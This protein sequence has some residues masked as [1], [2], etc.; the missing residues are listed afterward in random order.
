MDKYDLTDNVYGR[1]TVLGL[2]GKTGHERWL[3]KCSCGEITY[4]STSNLT[5]GR[6]QSC[7]CLKRDSNKSRGTYV[8]NGNVTY[9]AW[10]NL[11]YNRTFYAAE[12]NGIDKVDPR[13]SEFENFVA[14]LGKKPGKGWYL[15]R[16]D[17][18]LPYNKENCEWAKMPEGKRKMFYYN[19]KH[20]H[21]ETN[22]TIPELSRRLSISE[23]TIYE[24]LRK[25]KT[26]LEA[27]RK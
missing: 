25:G 9:A 27:I 17:K 3:C 12:G 8:K 13:W 4:S 1:L 22:E 21:P 19:T 16:I 26:L 11:I 15:N 24:R 14:D 5:G 18:D 2:S 10:Y 7:G 20:R 23:G 6:K